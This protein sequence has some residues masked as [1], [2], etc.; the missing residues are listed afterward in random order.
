[1]PLTGWQISASQNALI[2]P[3]TALYDSNGA[4][5]AGLA[6]R[7]TAALQTNSSWIQHILFLIFMNQPPSQNAPVL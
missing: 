4:G 1:M 2:L 3:E 6:E 7:G 5:R